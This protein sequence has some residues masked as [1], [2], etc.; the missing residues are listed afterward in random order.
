MQLGCPRLG[1]ATITNVGDRN[2]TT[3]SRAGSNAG[4]ANLPAASVKVP[5]LDLSR[6]YRLVGPLLLSAVEDVL[7]SQKFIL[8][9]QVAEFERAAAEKCGVAHAVGCSSGTDA[10]WLAIEG[11]EI[12]PGDAVVT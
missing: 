7:S 2:E 3:P 1:T 5:I 11:V 12:G 4:A 8:G 9:P 10:L 6:E